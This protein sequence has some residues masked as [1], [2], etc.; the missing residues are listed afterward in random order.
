MTRRDERGNRKNPIPINTVSRFYRIPYFRE[1]MK[2][3]KKSRKNQ[4]IQDQNWL[5]A[6]LTKF[7]NP[8][9]NSFLPS[10]FPN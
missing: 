2:T 9:F 4:R 6:F 7:A 10:V 8:I 1:K 3:E 5:E